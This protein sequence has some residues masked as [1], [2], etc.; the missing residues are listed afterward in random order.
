MNDVVTIVQDT[1]GSPV[2]DVTSP[3][4]V[5]SSRGRLIGTVNTRVTDARRN[6]VA[7]S[8]FSAWSSDTAPTGY[9]VG[10]GSVGRYPVGSFVGTM[11]LLVDGGVS[12][13]MMA[14]IPG[15]PGKAAPPRT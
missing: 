6:Y 3:T 5:A 8:V 10:T 14:M 13:H 1:S 15:R 7:N 11:N 12:D 9:T 4:G 2:V